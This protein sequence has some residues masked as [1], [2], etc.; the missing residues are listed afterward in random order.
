MRRRK[1]TDPGPRGFEDLL[2]AAQAGD[3]EALGELWS[4]YQGRVRGYLASFDAG[5]AED[6][7]SE[8][9][10]GVAQALR[11]FCGD[12]AQF[13]AWL[14]T[15]AHRRM[16]DL[17]RR[18]TRRRTDAVGAVPEVVQLEDAAAALLSAEE[19]SEVKGVL[20]L[21][22]A[23]QAQAILLRVL[24][25]LSVAQVAEILD[26]KPGTVR[27]LTHRGLQHL[28]VAL[29]PEQAPRPARRPHQVA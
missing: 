26:K 6:L 15:I 29:S 13:R 24:G 18:T 12:E 22:P 20:A 27:V 5:A 10:I 17:R 1:R 3:Q 4:I 2:G 8:T 23:E 16:L 19:V 11:H 14:F 25:D 7:S 21:L 28:A 9:W